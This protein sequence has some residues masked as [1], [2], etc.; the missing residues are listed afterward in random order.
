MIVNRSDCILYDRNMCSSRRF[1]QNYSLVPWNLNRRS[2]VAPP[3][4]ASWCWWVSCQMRR[5][6]FSVRVWKSSVAANG[7]K[8]ECSCSDPSS[9]ASSE[10]ADPLDTKTS[11]LRPNCV[12][13]QHD[14]KIITENVHAQ[15]TQTPVPPT[16]RMKWS[17]RIR[18][19]RRLKHE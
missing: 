5:T 13:S 7:R 18:I 19:L 16:E 9:K 2:L 12:K 11:L 10:K 14:T 3:T 17:W 8:G 1:E 4:K 6:S 15:H